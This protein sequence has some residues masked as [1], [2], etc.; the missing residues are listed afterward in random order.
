MSKSGKSSFTKYY[1]N[2]EYR[3][4]HL[5]YIKQ[6]VECS[7][8]KVMV[9]RANMPAHKKT[10]KHQ[11]LGEKHVIKE[12]RKADLKKKKDKLYDSIIKKISKLSI[13]EL[14]KILKK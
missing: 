6:K 2:P 9:A 12:K 5:N 7:L 8:C 11:F 4:K 3:E 10:K 14:Q 13:E 1:A